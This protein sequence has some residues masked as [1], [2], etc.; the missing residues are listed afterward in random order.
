MLAVWVLAAVLV[1]CLV[2]GLCI[3]MN[4]WWQ[5][6]E[7]PNK[8]DSAYKLKLSEHDLQQIANLEGLD[9]QFLR[10]MAQKKLADIDLRRRK[11]AIL[12]EEQERR[13]PP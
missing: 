1:L 12:L 3:W 4:V 7:L 5:R 10:M 13:R 11:R 8:Y 6:R 2:Y 9:P